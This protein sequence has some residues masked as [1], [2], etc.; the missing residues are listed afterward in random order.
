MT[1]PERGGFLKWPF[2]QIQPSSALLPTEKFLWDTCA[3]GVT[4]EGGSTLDLGGGVL[5]CDVSLGWNTAI[6]NGSVNGNITFAAGNQ[7]VS[8]CGNLGGTGDISIGVVNSG[9]PDLHPVYT[10]T[11]NLGGH[12]LTKGLKLVGDTTV[13]NGKLVLA[14]DMT[15]SLYDIQARTVTIGKDTT[16]DL[17]SH[18]FS[19]NLAVESDTAIGNGTIG[20]NV[21]VKDGKSVRFFGETKI[22]SN[23]E[24]GEGLVSYNGLVEAGKTKIQA[25]HRP[26]ESPIGAPVY[27]G[28]LKELTVSEK[29]IV[30]T[31]RATSL[32]NGLEIQSQ[33]DLMIKGMTITADN[34][35]SVGQNTITLNDVTIKLSQA[36]YDETEGVFLFDL[37]TLI[38]CDLVMENVL[39]DAS[40]LTLPES[41]DPANKSVVFDFG[42]D[43]T[44]DPQTAK[45]ITLL[46]GGYGSR[47]MSID[48]QGR[49]VFTA[50]VPTPEPTTGTLSLLA[51]A[52]L[53]ARRRRK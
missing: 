14:H 3:G 44:I 39:L 10:S 49:P 24:V 34:K 48:G 45:N 7:Q 30:G 42:D 51:L 23:N 16:V 26:L 12:T 13:S 5:S 19:H 33:A 6:G 8:L 1:K 52:A 25:L 21:T 40:D 4:L 22:D 31:G 17:N 20:G 35:I 37:G 9:S 47:T 11:L 32:A 2:A 41:F 18:T 38:N 15:W 28:L 27:P 36:H 53:A 50:L 29:E 43:V 46:M